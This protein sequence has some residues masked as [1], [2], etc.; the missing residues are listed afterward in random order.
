MVNPMDKFTEKLPQYLEDGLTEIETIELERHLAEC[1]VC[2]AEF[3][4]LTRFDRL[5]EAAPMAAPP[6]NFVPMVEA[7]LARRLHRRRTMLGML[8]IGSVLAV[9]AAILTWG[10]LA[11]G[12]ELWQ[13]AAT[14]D[15]G[16]V[17]FDVL[18]SIIAVGAVIGKIAAVLFDALVKL[19][20]HPA[21][22][23]YV[24][25][26]VGLVWLWVQLFRWT[27]FAHQP[28]EISR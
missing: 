8:V 13:W 27:N 22:W 2:Q 7:K 21:L 16:R 9:I 23:G 1:A 11:S 15:F 25:V 3:D 17:W 28:V 24:S 4:A 18:N 12:A 14:D 19:M 26:G 10:V 5:L 20:R 6:P